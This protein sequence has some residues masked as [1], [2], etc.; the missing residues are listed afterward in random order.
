MKGH[1]R[2]RMWVVALAALMLWL[3]ATVAMAEATVIVQVRNQN[4]SPADGTV[5][6]TAAGGRT[7]SCHTQA[8]RCQMA[9]VPGG[10]GTV[11]FVP[12]TGPAPAPR[13]VMVAP[14]GNVSLIVQ[15][16]R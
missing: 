8:G 12:A 1:H 6:L 15:S 14:S 5:T 7:F 9:G 3:L 11:T 4:G 10:M 13:P 2:V 16:G